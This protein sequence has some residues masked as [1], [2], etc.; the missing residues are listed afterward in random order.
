MKN[1]FFILIVVFSFFSCQDKNLGKFVVNQKYF[2]G[3][4]KLKKIQ[5][6]SMGG[7]TID[8]V[9]EKNNEEKFFNTKKGDTISLKQDAMF[10]DYEL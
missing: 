1:L 10:G 9:I 3:L 2:Y 6:I 7:D 4:N 5:L 8:V